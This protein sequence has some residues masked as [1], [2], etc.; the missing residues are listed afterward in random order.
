M[1]K[2]IDPDSLNQAT[3]VVIST[4]AKTVQLLVAGNLSTDGVSL[5]AVYS[6]LKEEWKTDADLVKHPFP[7][8]PITDTQFEFINGWDFADDT[9]RYLVRDGGWAVKDSGG[10]SLEEW[11]CII[12][13]GSVGATDQIYFQQ[14]AA[15]AKANAQLAGAMN[16]AVKIYGDSTHGDF[17]YRSYF[18]LFVREYQK[19]YPL[20]QIS[21]IGVTTMTYKD[22]GFPLANATDA[23]ITHEDAT[24]STD[25]P[26]SGMS[27]TWHA[28][29]QQRSIGGTAYDFHV[30]IDGNNGTAE[31]IYEFVQWSL[32]QT[33]D[34][35]AGAGEH[36]GNVTTALL[37]FVGDSLY[38]LRQAEGGVY[39]DDF[40]TAD[41]NRL[42]FADDDTSTA[43]QF[44][45]TAALTI[46][47]GDNL[48]N[49]ASAKY[50]VFFTNDDAGDN[51]GYDFGTANAIIV[52]DADDVDMAGDVD[53]NASIQHS[54][55]YD[56][57]VQR[58][59]GSDGE[60]APIT[61]VAMGLGTA[62]Y[63]VATGTITRSTTNTISLVAAL[64]R[65]YSNPA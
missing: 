48:V 21:D 39:I 32:R 40:Q 18:K 11:A 52:D 44:P 17:D 51:A 63:V 9:S 27:I 59:T 35:D 64:E 4:A 45:Y 54:F 13:L 15:G 56:T 47:F 25:A 24:V 38:T 28:T 34:I 16:Q 3:E 43:L 42:Y 60:D 57:N 12:S 61:V 6:F 36:I 41:I 37:Q 29:A 19:T 10:V 58:G 50:W 46:N 26:Y 62:Q 7:M 65:N 30:I 2:I 14:V 23:K 31:Q 1:A 53:G 5:K 49:D 20:S 22:Y 33:T 8:Q 55:A